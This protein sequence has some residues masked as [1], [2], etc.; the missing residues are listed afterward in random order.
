M[1]QIQQ[2]QQRKF[3]LLKPKLYRYEFVDKQYL[4]YQEHSIEIKSARRFYK[5]FNYV[6][7]V[8]IYIYNRFN[9]R[10]YTRKV[11]N[12]VIKNDVPFN[13]LRHIIRLDDY[14]PDPAL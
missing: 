14:D 13:Q 8:K 4:K 12:E 2:I 3:Y 7:E 11:S 10:V 1:Q 5:D 9:D 6:P